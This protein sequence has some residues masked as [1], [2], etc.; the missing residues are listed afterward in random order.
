MGLVLLICIGLVLFFFHQPQSPTP[1][2]AQENSIPQP[3]RAIAVKTD[4]L[5]A[6]PVPAQLPRKAAQ[7]AAQADPNDPDQVFSADH[8]QQERLPIDRS[9]DSKPFLSI[10]PLEPPNYTRE[11]LAEKL[12]F[13]TDIQEVKQLKSQLSL[14]T[15]VEDAVPAGVKVVDTQPGSIFEKMGLQ[16]GDIIIAVDW[17]DIETLDDSM[18][19]YESIRS[20]SKGTLAIIRGG[21]AMTLNYV[22]E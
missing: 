22:N 15:H 2:I 12:G 17:K 20:S 3:R 6:G 7:V 16:P 10:S 18:E 11:E 5:A 8:V 4:S 21:N 9:A 13:A 14:E 1:K 19:I